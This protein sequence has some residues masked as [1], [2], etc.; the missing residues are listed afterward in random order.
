MGLSIHFVYCICV[1]NDG[2]QVDTWIDKN[3]LDKNVKLL[4]C[5]GVV[6]LKFRGN[7][8]TVALTD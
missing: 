3:P 4:Y 8:A 1:Q 7:D 2:G 5:P 6:M